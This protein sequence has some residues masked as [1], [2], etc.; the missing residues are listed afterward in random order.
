[1]VI[2]CAKS[3]EQLSPKAIE[4]DKLF[5]A[6]EKEKAFNDA[7]LVAEEGKVIFRKAVGFSNFEM[8]YLLKES[9]RSTDET[10]RY[11]VF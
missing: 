10:L 7:V 11:L 4:I 2:A 8:P 6:L 9:Y 3:S 1:M 5:T